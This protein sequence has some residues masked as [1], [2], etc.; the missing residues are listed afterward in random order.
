MMSLNISYSYLESK[1]VAH[2]SGLCLCNRMAIINTSTKEQLVCDKN[3]IASTSK[4][5][6]TFK[7]MLFLMGG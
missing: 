7:Q 5:E 4:I 3:S 2:L 6:L 1:E